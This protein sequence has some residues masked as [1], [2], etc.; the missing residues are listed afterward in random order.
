MHSRPQRRYLIL[1]C[2]TSHMILIFS[3]P[4]NLSTFNV[5]I[6]RWSNFS[7]SSVMPTKGSAP[8]VAKGSDAQKGDGCFRNSCVSCTHETGGSL[9]DLSQFVRYC[10]R[11]VRI[12]NGESQVKFTLICKLG[13]EMGLYHRGMKIG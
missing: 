12:L 7:F 3:Q 4:S 2:V 8:F 11:P 13:M 6:F 9:A 1:P 10:C 5:I